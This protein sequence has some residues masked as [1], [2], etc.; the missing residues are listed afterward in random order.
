MKRY[1]RLSVLT[2]CCVFVQG[3]HAGKVQKCVAADG[4]VTFTDTGCVVLE[5]MPKAGGE[6][7]ARRPEGRAFETPATRLRSVSGPS[8]GKA[9]AS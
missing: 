6:G 9:N 4:S 1:F 3:A 8:R 2:L 5:P 7:N